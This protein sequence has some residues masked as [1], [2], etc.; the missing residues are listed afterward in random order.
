MLEAEAVASSP[1]PV[2]AAMGQGRPADV[3]EWPLG[4]WVELCN[5]RQQLRTKLTWVSPQQS[6]FLFT[7]E[8]GSTQSM[9]RRMRDKLLTQGQLR[10][11]EAIA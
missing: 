2:Q 5:E 6:L 4:T 8:D 1:M 9:T 7:A 10:R 11:L 3:A